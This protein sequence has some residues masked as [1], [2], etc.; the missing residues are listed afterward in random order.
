MAEESSGGRGKML[1]DG[2]GWVRPGRIWKGG[3][4]IQ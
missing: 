4:R 1:I 2:I 3:R